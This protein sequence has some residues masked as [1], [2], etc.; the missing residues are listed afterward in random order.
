M[1]IICGRK[2]EGKEM[3]TDKLHGRRNVTREQLKKDP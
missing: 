2:N 1:G 3:L